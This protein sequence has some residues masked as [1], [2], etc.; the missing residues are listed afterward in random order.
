[1]RFFKRDDARLITCPSCCQLISADSATCEMC[2]TDLSDLPAERR[3]AAF[4]AGTIGQ[5]GSP[6]AR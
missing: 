3:E 5:S 4:T 2:G 6:Y 1:M